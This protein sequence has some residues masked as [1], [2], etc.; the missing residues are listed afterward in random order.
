MALLENGRAVPDAWTFIPDDAPVPADGKV[1][2]TLARLAAEIDA[3]SGR[4]LGVRLASHEG[5]EAVAPYLDDVALIAVDFPKFRDGRGFTTARALRERYGFT[6]EIRAVGHTIPDQYRFLTRVGFTT[7]VVPDTANL[8]SWAK[9][10]T[11]ITV[12]Y[13]PAPHSATPAELLRRRFAP[14]NAAAGTPSPLEGEGG[15]RPER[16]E[17]WEGEGSQGPDL[18]NTP[19]PPMRAHGSLPLP[20]GERGSETRAG[21]AV[22]ATL[23]RRVGS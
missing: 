21:G 15:A 18:V 12:D 11:E 10:L 9:A 1:I 3:L 14:V 8:D 19:H 16:S 20:Q 4:D 6:G 2:V 17:G 22:S 5:A 23:T 7:V 13:Q